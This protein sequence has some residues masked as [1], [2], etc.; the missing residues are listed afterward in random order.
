VYNL[1]PNWTAVGGGGVFSAYVGP[2]VYGYVSPGTTTVYDGREAGIIKAGLNIGTDGHY[3]DEGLFAFKP[4]VTINNFA[5]SPLT[6]DVENQYGENPVWMTIEI[7]T[8]V[9]GDRSDNTVYQFVPTTNPAGWHTVDAGAGLW[10]KWNNNNGDVTGNPLI[11]ISQVAAAHTGLNVVRAYL[12]LGMG[13]SYH[14]SAGL[15]TVAWVDTATLGGV[16]YDFVVPHPYCTTGDSTISHTCDVTQC[17]AQCDALHGCPPKIDGD[18]CKYL[19]NCN[20]DPAACTCNYAGSQYCPVPGTVNGTTCYYGT[21]TCVADGCEGLLTAQMGCHDTCDPVLGPIDT[22]G[23]QTYNVLLT[24][25]FNNGIFNLTGTAKDNCSN[26]KISKYY[27][28]TGV[29]SCDD[30]NPFLITGNMDPTDGSYNSLLEN[31]KKFNVQYIHDGQNFACVKSWDVLDKVGNCNCSYFDTDILPPD[32]SYDIYLNQQLYPNEYMMCGSN[33]WLN[34]TVCDSQSLIQGGEYFIDPAFNTV[35]EPW[36]GI[37]MNVLREFID[38]NGHHCAVIGANVDTSQ[39]SDGTHYIKLRGKDIVENWGKF[40]QCS[41]VSFIKDTTHPITTKT[42]VPAD[43]KKVV[44]SNGEGNGLGLTDGCYYVKQGTQI[45]LTAQDPDPQGTGEFADNVVIYYEV[46]WRLD[47]AHDWALDSSGQSTVNGDVWI[48]LSKDSYHKIVYWSVDSCGNA[49]EKHYELDIVDTQAPNMWKTVGSPSHLVDPNCNPQTQSCDYYVTTATDITL[50][51]VDQNP[52]P[53]DNVTLHYSWVNLQDQTSYNGSVNAE[54][55]TFNYPTDSEHKLYFWCSDAL[56]N[57]AGNLDVVYETDYVDTTKPHT[58]KTVTGPQQPGT[59]NIHKYITNNTLIELTCTDQQPH[60][61]DHVT[62]NWELYWNQNCVEPIWQLIGSG[63]SDGYKSFTNLQDSCHKLVYYC[64]DILGN[65]EET[66]V[67][68]DAV[69]NKYPLVN[70]V[71]GQLQ[72]AYSGTP[73][74]YAYTYDVA[75]P[76]VYITTATPITLTCE[77]QQPHPVDDVKIYYK[78]YVD[79]Q[80][81]RDWAQYTVPFTYPEDTYHELYYYCIDSL[82]NKGP[83]HVEMDIVDTQPPVSQKTLGTP[84]HACT[85]DE[86]STYYPQMSDPTDGCYFITQQTPITLTCADGQPHPVDH[87]VIKYR[88]N[89]NGGGFTGWMTYAGTFTF[90]QDSAHVLQWYCE[91]ALGNTETT[92]VEYDIV[93]SLPPVGSKEVGNPKLD[94]SGVKFR[95]GGTGGTAGWS[96][97]QA[98]S[99]MY[100]VKMTTSTNTAWGG[101]ALPYSGV[102]LNTITSFNY[103]SYVVNAGTF[104]QLAIWPSFYLDANNDGT[105]DYYLQC[106]PY[107]TYGNPTLNTWTQYDIYNMR[108]ESYEETCDYPSA[109]PTLAQYINGSAVSV[110]CPG[111]PANMFATREYGSL[112]I[113]KTEMR[114]G[115]GN[116]W[117]GF[118]GYTDD[119]TI[120]GNAILSEPLWFANSSTPV[121]LNCADQNPHPVD[122]EKMCYRVSFD[123]PENPWLTSQYCTQFGGAMNGEWCCVQ[124]DQQ[125]LPY[126]FTFQEDSLH[127]LEFYCE[128]ALGNRN[129]P[130]V[131]YFKVDS[132]PPVIA[133]GIQGPSSGNCLPQN[134][135][136]VCF[137]DGV[138]NITVQMTDPDPTGRGCNVSGVTCEWEYY[139]DDNHQQFFGWYDT[140]PVHFPEETKHEL[141]IRCW[142]AL[143]NQ[144]TEDVETFYVDKT[145]PVTTKSYV[146]PQYVVITNGTEGNVSV[147]LLG[148]AGNFSILAKT[149]ITDVPTSVITGDVGVS[150]ASGTTIGVPCGEVNG[151][152]YSVDA[153]GPLCRVTNAPLLTQA[154]SDMEAAYTSLSGLTPNHTG[155][156]TGDISGMTLAPGIYKWTTGLLINAGGTP[157]HNGVTLDC[158]GNA[159]AVFIFQ[160]AQTLA[161]GSGAKVTLSGSCQASNI[162][163]VV[164]GTT[165]LG[166]TSVFNGNILAGPGTSTIALLNGATLNGR[167]LGQTDVTLIAD[168]IS[169]PNATTTG[170][171]TGNE[172]TRWITSGTNVTLSVY[173]AGPHKSGIKETKYRVTL[174]NGNEPC[175]NT[176]L[177]QQMTG[178]GDYQTYTAPFTIAEDSCHLIEYYSVDN[179]NKTETVKKQC[180]FV[181]NKP[182]ISTKTFDGLHVPCSQQLACANQSSCDYYINQNTQIILNCTNQ[183]QPHPV[184]NVT[185]VT[186]YY[187]YFVDDV[188]HQDWTQYT[189]PIQYNEDSKHTLEWYCEDALGNRETTHIQIER[190]D[191]T[192]PTTVKT[193]SGPTYPMG[194]Q[195]NYWVTSDTAITLT[196]TDGGAICAA[197]PA[198]LYYQVW[199]DH[200]CDGTVDTEIMNGSVQTDANC[201]LN[202]TIYLNKE[203]LNEIRWYAVDALGN[204][205]NGGQWITQQHKVDN[206]PPH[207]LILKPV[208]G[209]YSIGED[210]PIVAD[211]KDLNNAN[212]SCESY[213]QNC[214]ELGTNCSVGIADGAQCY[215]YLVDVEFLNTNPED[216]MFEMHNKVD[217]ITNGTFL[218]NAAAH[219]CQ[220]YATVLDDESLHDG[221]HILVVSAK[222]K[223]GNTAN[224]FD[225]I[226]LAINEACGGCW[227]NDPY[228][229]C[230]ES[231]VRDV[232]QD[233]ITSW[234]LPKIGIDNHDPVVMITAPSENSLFGGE[235]VFVSANVSDSENG[236]ITSTITSGTPCYIT[237][238]GVS[239]GTVPYDNVARKCVGTVMIP[240]DT[241]FPQG[242]QALKV[243]IADNAGN[244]GSDSVNVNVDTTKPVLD[245]II[246]SQNQ[247]VKGTIEVTAHVSDANLNASQIK[248]STDNGQTWHDTWYCNPSTYCYDWDT[249]TATDGMAYG[250]VAKA[251]DL[252]DN[253]GYSDAVIVIVDNGAPDGVYV[254]SPVANAI[255]Q[256]TITL[257]ALATDYISGV[258]SVKIYVN[259][260]VWNCDATLIGGTWQCSFNS[261]SLLDGQYT[262]Y[263]VA[264]DSLGHQT[265]SASVPFTIDNNAPLV[266]DSFGHMSTGNYSYDT[267]G[268]ITWYWSPSSDAGSGIDHYIFDF[269]GDYIVVYGTQNPE[270]WITYTM[271][272]LYNGPYSVRVEAIDKAGHGSGWTAYDH[273]TVDTIKP[274]DIDVS[275]GSTE[276]GSKPLYY[277]TNGAYN[278]VWT[279]GIDANL[280]NYKL[281]ENG[282]SIYTGLGMSKAFSGVADGTYEY[283]VVSTDKAGW[284]TTSNKIT[285]TVDKVAPTIA[286]SGPTGFMGM[287]TFTF[288]ASDAGSG[289]EKIVVSDSNTPFVTCFGLESGWCMVIGG[290][291][292]DLTAYDKAGNHASDNTNGAPADTT[293]PMITYT[294]PSG[295]I[296]TNNP[297]LRVTTDEPAKCYYGTVDSIDPLIMTPMGGSY[298]TDHSVL[299]ALA[300]G[301]GLYVYHVQCQDVAG[302]WMEHSKTI[303]FY[304]DTTGQ[305]CY[306]TDM[307]AGWNT[308]FLPQLI[309]DDMNF[310]CGVKPYTTA[311][312]LSSIAGKYGIIW[313]Y[314]SS[315]DMWRFYKP[316]Y[317]HNTLLSFNDQTSSPYY[318]KITEPVRLGLQCENECSTCTPNCA[319]KVCGDDGCGGSCGQCGDGY[320]CINYQCQTTPV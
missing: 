124:K 283:Y 174:M 235:Q 304:V 51:C 158:G 289:L 25:P 79:G 212:G 10:Q 292:V 238:G 249:T 214:S 73:F 306:S 171:T 260:V 215:A 26:I 250:I 96:T 240:E 92:H 269:G 236:Q 125:L 99:G 112:K 197:G 219:Q 166:T 226:K 107:Y 43:E 65:T 87:T 116:P 59:G 288:T 106:E 300:D 62:L 66:Q 101:A 201:N 157:D 67:E 150:P 44:C 19:G 139:L 310:S 156:G 182:P 272:D 173:D 164:A 89:V 14:G 222:D 118:V 71:V 266:P 195:P 34:A 91:D 54:S 27:I 155:V 60:P 264:T 315:N 229:L 111:H 216:N 208:D 95:T 21:R 278:I 285:V 263:A 248:I 39:L 47:E 151:T 188:L 147:N 245:I 228:D 159:S 251:T 127:D 319:D 279:G 135:N 141:H 81:S 64:A 41:N 314:D 161:V 30:Y 90:Q 255:A 254:V 104:G 276:K 213:G 177:C 86:Q 4:T 103:W 70:K 146:G 28:G 102:A 191:T 11:S 187:R 203:C 265:T 31:V 160:I 221:I 117:A 37:W 284:S 110:P 115:P 130:D 7:D 85:T 287:W 204:M 253:T 200:N 1:Q 23:P 8:G 17:G 68:I 105:W 242:T 144:M 176:E 218:Y 179:V 202:K 293:P 290:T 277:D 320:Y 162:Y 211:V 131:E 69:D 223:L 299:L 172:T 183:Q 97:E 29:G 199:W 56:G 114:T 75:D 32:C 181:N 282:V 154:V 122:H 295:R 142:D 301:D 140:F 49:E 291:Y 36:T 303:V 168:T 38:G 257:K 180:T 297:M 13:D 24:P 274:T 256:G 46:Y 271:S 55:Y 192:P 220:G 294:E 194:D 15:G 35:P 72:Y 262:A 132:T 58:E 169:L 137:L 268:T 52:H 252:A 298:D 209:W 312:V 237:L 186:I 234:N 78:Y 88:Y 12:R 258:Q 231:C 18:Y 273:V 296:T 241:D 123:D 129:F 243:E 233:I 205:E 93:D 190:V 165:T 227:H 286:L 261:N 149:A 6:Y 108:C 109:A 53:V 20:T 170:N 5:A 217:L 230:E 121:T 153:A 61:S 22:V 148:T 246:P 42:I 244:L 138:T 318:I 113:I 16:T 275:A 136:D 210:I 3:E 196:T 225:E 50:H 280:D 40:I 63:S 48:T 143:G 74:T 80:L 2:P 77:D 133:K 311:D 270:G 33:A 57:T 152:I 206:T 185:N 83:T 302:N 100:S 239:M 281:Y 126:T 317:A 120:N 82:G 175:T 247:F 313:Y 128:D 76:S 224:S 119:V 94:R 145:P 9:V 308:F 178:S 259:T 189:A 267:D 184:G 193:F 316:G 207:I 307:N 305:Y 45:H 198:T 163:W 98:H 167:A 134:P 84:Q 232:L 309:L